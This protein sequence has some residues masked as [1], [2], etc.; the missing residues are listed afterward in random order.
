MC[1]TLAG[2]L[3]ACQAGP[4]PQ[5]T[6]TIPW[7]TVRQGLTVSTVAGSGKLGDLG[8]GYVDGPALQAEFRRPA[9]LAMDAAG[10][11]YIADEKNH[12]IRVLTRNGIVSTVAGSGPTG[13]AQGGYVDG[14]ADA[15][16]FADPIG[17]CVAA[18]GSL[19]VADSDNQRI[20]RIAPVGTPSSF[21]PTASACRGGTARVLGGNGSV[22]TWAGSGDSV[23]LIG[24]YLDGPGEVAQFNRPYDVAVDDQG[25]LFVADYFNNV[26]R[27]IGTD[28]RVFTL[29]GNGLPGHKDG[30]SGATQLAYPNRLILRSG[31]LYFTEGHSRDMWEM[32]S[33]NHVR[34]LTLQG[35][36]STVAGSGAAGYADGPSAVAQFDTPMGIDVD[37]R[38]NIY[39][40]EYLGHCIRII[41]PDGQVHTLAG[42]CG[43][44]GYQDGPATTALFSYPMDV[45][46]SEAEHVLYVA[47]FGNHRIRAIT[48]P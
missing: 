17:L 25:N 36:V 39:V 29:A 30:P 4:I 32:E 37:A 12:R 27:R 20:R 33:G 24:G 23:K 8:G 2:L 43:T 47:D 42:T 31:I 41:T 19:Y 11:V 5:V 15:A 45:L 7:P 28:G 14:P 3:A 26:I 18:D 35:Q 9:A 46:V 44:Q 21:R 22:S 40:S 48:L 6:P 13:A 10:N 1:C 38:G 34:K 16:R